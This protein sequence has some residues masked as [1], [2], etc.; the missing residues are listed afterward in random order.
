MNWVLQHIDGVTNAKK[1][2]AK[3]GVDLEMVLACLRVFKHHKMI[4]LVDMFFY[5]NRYECTPRAGELLGGNKPKI[6]QEALEYATT[7]GDAT[8]SE[9]DTSL[10][11]TL[12]ASAASSEIHP[13]Q[14]F[15]RQQRKWRAVLA[16][17]YLCSNRHMSVSDFWIHKLQPTTP[18][19]ESSLLPKTELS[20]SETTADST[21]RGTDKGIVMS[22]A[23]WKTAF[24]TLDHRRCV[25]F[26]VI[27]GILRRVHNFP[28]AIDNHN[29]NN[30]NNTPL[31]KM[32]PGGGGGV[33]VEEAK[34][35]GKVAHMMN[36]RNCDD[37]IVTEFGQPLEDLIELVKRVTKRKVVSI[38][39]TVSEGSA[40]V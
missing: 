18:P 31:T 37:A 7:S 26:G 16:D 38:R 25:T 8:D 24:Q 15:R 3:S 32:V 21:T 19:L 30:N 11:Q 22:N 12:A 39:C 28:I 17:F 33:T 36:G 20:S 2:S 29:N 14:I 5:S 27:H 34:L 6:L 13:V 23:D 9:L 1:I 4:A 10:H 35:A 40:Y